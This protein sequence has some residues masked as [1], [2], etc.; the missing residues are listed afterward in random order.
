MDCMYTNFFYKKKKKLEFNVGVRAENT[1]REYKFKSIVDPITN[2]YRKKTTENLYILPSLN[3]KYNTTDKSNLPV[4]KT[5]TKPVL[6]GSLDI[7]LINADGT[8]E[9]GNSD[10]EN[11]ENLNADLKFELFPTS[12]EMFA[13][14]LFAKYIDNPIERT[15]QASATG[16]G[17]TITYFNNDS[18]TLFGAEF[19]FLVQLSRLHDNLNGFSF[20]LN[21]S[22]MITEP[23]VNKNRPA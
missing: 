8:T 1:I 17:Q 2:P 15:I 7:N 21:T 20:G 18:A 5:N 9:R 6:F 13:A 19:E 12:K 3:I 23:T 16:S 14:T 4:S 22:L 11:S 10:I